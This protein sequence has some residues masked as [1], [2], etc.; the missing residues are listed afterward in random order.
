MDRNTKREREIQARESIIRGKWTLMVI[1][2]NTLSGKGA[3]VSLERVC[4]LILTLVNLSPLWACFQFCKSGF[5]ARR[6]SSSS[7]VLEK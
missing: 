6:L 2:L 4:A 7:E 5:W 1:R 3:P